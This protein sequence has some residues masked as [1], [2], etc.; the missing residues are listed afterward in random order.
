[1]ITDVRM[2]GLMVEAT[3]L[4]AR[5]V[6]KREDLPHL[7]ATITEQSFLVKRIVRQHHRRVKLVFLLERAGAETEQ[8]LEKFI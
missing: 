1:M 5:G 3:D 8:L 2:M 7:I 4:G 6:I